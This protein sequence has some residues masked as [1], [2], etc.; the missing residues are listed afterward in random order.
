L[1]KQRHQLFVAFLSLADAFVV[2]LA[3]YVAWGVRRLTVEQSLA[4]DWVTLLKEPLFLVAAPLAVLML[5][6]FGVYQPRRDRSVWGEQRQ[7]IKASFAAIAA[8]ILML[9]VVG[10][11]SAIVFANSPTT[12]VL[13]HAV[14]AGRVQ[15]VSLALVQTLLLCVHRLIFRAV[16]RSIRRR[17]WNM[18]HVVVVGVGRLGRIVCRTLERNTWTGIEVSYFISHRDTTRRTTLLG[19]PVLGG[20]DDL[21]RALEDR[22]PDAV[23]LAMP[24][25]RAAEL[26]RLLK[27]LERFAVDIRIIPDVQPRYLPHSMVVGELDGMPILS[28]RENPH[29]GLGGFGKR[30]IDLIGSITGLILFMPLMLLIAAVVRLTSPGP[31]VFKQTRV[32]LGGETFQ[33]Y[34]FRTMF[35]ADDEKREPSWTARN[36]ARVTPVGRWLRR[37]SLDELPQL[38]NVLLGDMSLVGPRPERPE[39]IAQFRENWRGYILRQHVKAGITGWAQVNGLRGD[40]DLRKRLQLDLF[41]IRHWS[42]GFDLKILWLTMFRGF[43]HRNA[44]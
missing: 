27:Q 24:N 32:G 38:L 42:F 37:M 20:L 12:Q 30:T 19:K 6:I 1:V 8:I 40:T 36:D 2:T 17:G 29:H 22:K 21:E 7:I 23:Y 10:G 39:L 33:I 5:V 43:V 26:P 16:L 34:K 14:D 25:A 3:C 35:H 13:G 44:H 15:L 18:R 9:W 11:D 31:V 4:V 28:Y 41:Y